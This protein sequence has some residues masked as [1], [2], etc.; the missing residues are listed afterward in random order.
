MNG[1]TFG[2]GVH[3][4][5]WAFAERCEDGLGRGRKGNWGEQPQEYQRGVKQGKGYHDVWHALL[6]TVNGGGRQKE[7]HK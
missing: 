4:A 7:T 5:N 2:D 3:I 1:L 6:V